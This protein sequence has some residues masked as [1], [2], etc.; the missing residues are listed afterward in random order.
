MKKVFN[1]QFSEK[2]NCKIKLLLLIITI[3]LFKNTQSSQTDYFGAF[4]INYE[5]VKLFRK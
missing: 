3:L 2:Q 4:T 1:S 5:K